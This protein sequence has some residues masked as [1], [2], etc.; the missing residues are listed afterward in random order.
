[1]KGLSK[2]TQNC[3]TLPGELLCV[4]NEILMQ[5]AEKIKTFSCV[6]ARGEKEA[7]HLVPYLG[8]QRMPVTSSDKTS[9]AK[10]WIVKILWRELCVN[11]NNIIFNSIQL[12]SSIAMSHW[13]QV[14][15]HVPCTSVH[16]QVSGPREY[17]R[18][19]SPFPHSSSW[20]S[21][22]FETKNLVQCEFAWCSTG[23]LSIASTSRICFCCPTRQCFEI[24]TLFWSSIFFCAS[25]WGLL[26]AI[27]E[28]LFARLALSVL[29]FLVW[30]TRMAFSLALM[31][32]D[33]KGRGWWG[34]KR[35]PEVVTHP[36]GQA[37]T[38]RISESCAHDKVRGLLR[39]DCSA[40][41]FE[42]HCLIT[43]PWLVLIINGA[44]SQ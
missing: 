3:S 34:R 15:S 36:S 42:F 9:Q 44:K 17:L 25:N 28:Y 14:A 13:D 2:T 18:R 12:S 19:L 4:C 26:F 33:E 41:C 5:Q 38:K 27:L 37:E 10:H 40:G 24:A 39:W 16:Y 11:L 30:I 32:N 1:M 7:T 31:V 22:H 6:Y 35:N 23:F 8:S 43:C 21:F 20:T 29:E